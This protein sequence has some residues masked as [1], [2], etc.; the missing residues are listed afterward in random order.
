MP[1]TLL[2]TDWVACSPL[3]RLH[4]ALPRLRAAWCLQV[5]YHPHLS[6][7]QYLSDPDTFARKWSSLWHA[8]TCLPN[9]HSDL[10]GRL[11]L[12]LLNEPDEY[13]LGWAGG[14]Q[15]RKFKPQGDYLL[16]AMDA[17]EEIFPGEAIFLIQGGG[18]VAL[19]TAW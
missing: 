16:A 15:G 5:D 7:L 19:G 1:I 4:A 9:Y 10:K 17:M 18:Q 14:R 2:C 11:L 8:I 12:D 3:D 13:N 6:E